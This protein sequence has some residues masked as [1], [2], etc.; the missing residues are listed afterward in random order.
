MYKIIFDSV[1]N[2]YFLLHRKWYN[3]WMWSSVLYTKRYYTFY[4]TDWEPKEY[5]SYEEAKSDLELVSKPIQK[6]LYQGDGKDI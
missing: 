5:S 1:R 6:T 2:K 3:L 4:E